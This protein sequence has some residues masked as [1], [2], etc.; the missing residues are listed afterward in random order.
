[1]SAKKWDQYTEH[2]ALVGQWDPGTNI[3]NRDIAEQ[4]RRHALP[5][6]VALQGVRI[7]RQV[8]ATLPS[9]L[10]KRGLDALEDIGMDIADAAGAS[11]ESFPVIGAIVKAGIQ[12]AVQIAEA[13]K[14]L[15]E[16]S[17]RGN[18]MTGRG[19]AIMVASTYAP[20]STNLRSSLRYAQAATMTGSRVL[21]APEDCAIRSFWAT[22]LRRGRGARKTCAARGPRVLGRSIRNAGER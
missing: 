20:T 17:I 5:D 6:Q 7:L 16:R 19:G 1:V 12:N 15:K 18:R 13:S 4:V 9:D 8:W 10:R 14:I 2:L 3:V 11:V 22:R 21:G